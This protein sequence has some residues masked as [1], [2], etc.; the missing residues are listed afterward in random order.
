MEHLEKLFKGIYYLNEADQLYLFLLLDILRN[1][2]TKEQYLE[3]LGDIYDNADEIFN[4]VKV[5]KS[6]GSQ[7]PPQK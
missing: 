2:L 5:E 7:I 3:L 6:K 4:D 1:Q